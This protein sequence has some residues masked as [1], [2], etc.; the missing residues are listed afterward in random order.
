M[1]QFALGSS[2]A[3]LLILLECRLAGG[4]TPVVVVG[5]LNRNAP[6]TLDGR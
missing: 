4:Q 6:V 2:M 1:L 5:P 3:S